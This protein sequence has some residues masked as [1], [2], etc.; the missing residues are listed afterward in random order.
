LLDAA[1]LLV[2]VNAV[3][4]GMLSLHALAWRLIPV[5]DRTARRLFRGAMTIAAIW[6]VERLIEP[7]A[8]A[9]ASLNIAVAGRALGAALVA[10]V[11]GATVR[12][13]TPGHAPNQTAAAAAQ[14]DR[15][16]PA[17]TLAWI[18]AFLIFGAAALRLRRL[19]H[20]FGQPGDLSDDSR[21]SSLPARHRHPG[22]GRGAAQPRRFDRRPAH[23]PV[24]PAPSRAG[25]D[26]GCRAGNRTAGDRRHR[27][28]GPAR[29]LGRAVAGMVQL[30]A[31]RLFRLR[32][33]RRHAVAVVDARGGRGVRRR[34]VRD[35]AHPGVA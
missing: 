32:R 23:D 10:A 13:L 2:V 15:W 26:R 17:R 11:L 8:D 25:A 33:R 35:P 24:R 14:S 29:A 6:A 20:L 34:P 1:R 19:R 12:R 27:R 9:V 21:V 3:G 5:S 4:R 30:A 16:A 31:R 22:R 7:A 18:A 28:G